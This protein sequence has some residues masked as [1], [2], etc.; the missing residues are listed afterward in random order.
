M[1]SSSEAPR[2]S[3]PDRDVVLADDDADP[4]RRGD[5]VQ[6]GGHAAA[7][8]VAQRPHPGDL[9]QQAGDQAVQRRGVGDDVG[10]DVQLAPGQHD[11][12]AVVADR[13]GHQDRVAR[14]GLGHPERAVVLDDARRRRC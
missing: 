8:G 7:G 12:D 13:P 9:R 5:L 10:L 14:P 11:R 3:A 2:T 4:G 1:P 6:D